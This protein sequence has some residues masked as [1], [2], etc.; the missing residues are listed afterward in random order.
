MTDDLFEWDDAKAVSNLRKHGVS[1]ED[2]RLIFRD[3][4][5]ML[6]LDM[7][8]DYGEERLIL[9]GIAGDRILVVVH[10]ERGDRTRIISARQANRRERHDYYQNQTSS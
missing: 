2:A 6:E 9:T 7:A 1:F 5:A 3:A 10:V 4:F 8:E